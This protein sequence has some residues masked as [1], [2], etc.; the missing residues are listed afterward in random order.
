MPGAGG[1]D[2]DGQMGFPGAGRAEQDHVIASSRN[3]P[4]TRVPGCATRFRSAAGWWSKSNS[5]SS[6]CPGNLAALI[7][8]DQRSCG[9]AASRPGC[10]RLTQEQGCRARPTDAFSQY[11]GRHRRRLHQQGPDQRRVTIKARIGRLPLKLRRPLITL[12]NGQWPHFHLAFMALFS[13]GVNK[14]SYSM[15][16]SP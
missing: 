2:P 6:L 5:S 7:R 12:H 10:N 8:K 13:V 9:T 3:T 4:G 16:D 11:G 15:T 1:P 14:G